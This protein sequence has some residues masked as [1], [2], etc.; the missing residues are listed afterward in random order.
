MREG[1]R[2]VDLRATAIDSLDL[3]GAAA[4]L[5]GGGLVAYPTETVYGLGG[6]CTTEI[7]A[8]I[9]ELKGRSPE[10][11]FIA[12]VRSADDVSRLSWTAAARELARIFW[13]GALTL[14]L[15]DPEAAF[16]WGVRSADGAVAVRVSPHPVVMR[17]LDAVAAPLLSTSANAAGESPARSGGEALEVVRRLGAGSEMW[18]LDVGLLPPSGPSTVVDCTASHPVVLREGT[19][20]LGRLRC[21]LPDI[22]GR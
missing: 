14:V 9:R 11:P 20:P 10:K 3:S 6:L 4:H 21:V 15:R 5:R 19:V 13:P 22:H 17:L 8:R 18:V 16:P 1:P 12:V 7:I 2:I